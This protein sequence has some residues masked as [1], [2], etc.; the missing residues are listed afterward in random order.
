M[1]HHTATVTSF[2][3]ISLLLFSI[4]A[5]SNVLAQTTSSNVNM[6]DL[7]SVLKEGIKKYQ[8]HR[9]EEALSYFD[10]VLE[11][12]S[13]H[14]L[15]L[16]YRGLTLMNLQKYQDAA[17]HY[18]KIL[19]DDPA[20][21][22]ALKN[23]GVVL[24]NLDRHTN[25]IKQFHKV[26]EIDSQDVTALQGMGLGFGN[27]GEYGDSLYYF[28]TAQ[29][30][31]PKNRIS[32][33][34]VEYTEI[35]IDKYYPKFKT[36]TPWSLQDSTLSSGAK[37]PGWIKNNAK[38]WSDGSISESDF[39]L[40][41]QFLIKKDIIRV[42][43]SSQPEKVTQTVP[44]WIK[45]NARWWADGKIND[46]GFLLGIQFLVS[47]GIIQVPSSELAV[48]EYPLVSST[49][50]NNHLREVSKKVAD[51]KRYIEFPN[52][53]WFIKKKYLRDPE[54]WNLD[55][56]GF[57]VIKSLPDPTYTIENGTYVVHYKVHINEIPSGIPFDYKRTLDKSLEF[58]SQQNFSYNG[59]LLVF[60]FTYTPEK[61]DSNVLVTWVVRDFGALGHATLGKGIVEVSM[62]D[63]ACDEDFQLY[64]L[65]TIEYIMRHEI[66]HSIGLKHSSDPK[67]IMY[68]TVT[69]SYGYCIVS[70]SKQ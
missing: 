9:F 53:S 7:D 25:S 34:Y 50:L 24:S 26:L 49:S 38:W 43:Q 40:G 23:L 31:D 51:E 66:G 44:D 57:N 61:Y 10:K 1:K 22:D 64:D 60:D 19:K 54:K 56:I 20:N 55:Q 45:N 70:A 68:P 30:I 14:A 33:N 16:N 42:P 46:S 28:E 12:R 63:Y 35:I 15:A 52:P 37:I 36:Q 3:L 17:N 21:L 13:D 32:K 5:P 62:G 47:N 8:G 67:N 29:K 4:V 6:Q 11:L 2:V 69:P 27:L 41:I 39:L 18:E 65:Q 59:K 48:V 58:W